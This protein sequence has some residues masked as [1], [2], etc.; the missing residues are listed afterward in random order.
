MTKFVIMLS[1]QIEYPL[2]AFRSSHSI[3]PRMIVLASVMIDGDM[4]AGR[5]FDLSLVVKFQ[6]CASGSDVYSM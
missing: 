2:S 4:E 1:W 6:L 3:T 5:V